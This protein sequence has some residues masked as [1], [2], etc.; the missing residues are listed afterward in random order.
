VCHYLRFLYR[1]LPSIVS[2]C[3]KPVSISLAASS[4]VVAI[5]HVH[6]SVSC[7]NIAASRCM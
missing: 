1:C 4:G 2:A 7:R 5:L 3:V 6:S